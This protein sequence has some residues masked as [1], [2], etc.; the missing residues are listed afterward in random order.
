M[1]AEFLYIRHHFRVTTFYV[2]IQNSFT[3]TYFNIF[4]PSVPRSANSYI[5]AFWMQLY[6]KVTAFWDVAPCKSRWNTGIS[7]VRTASI[8]RVT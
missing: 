8:I 4:L 1:F 6:M 5:Q 3:K 7:E 2:D